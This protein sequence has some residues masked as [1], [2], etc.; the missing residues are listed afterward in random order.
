VRGTF[1]CGGIMSIVMV[2]HSTIH[3]WK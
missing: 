1:S 3:E 2:S